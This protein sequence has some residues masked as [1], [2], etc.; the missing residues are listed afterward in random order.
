MDDLSLIHMLLTK[1][2]R[3][4]EPR[5]IGFV[6]SLDL[7]QFD[8]DH[9]GVAKSIRLQLIVLR[10]YIPSTT[11]PM[12]S[13]RALR[14][15]LGVCAACARQQH[16]VARRHFVTAPILRFDEVRESRL[17]RVATPSFWSSLIP[18][19]FRRSEQ[20]A[21][22]GEEGQEV[23]AVA[24]PKARRKW[25]PYTTFII[26]AV[27]IGSNAIQMISL[28]NEMT[29]FSRHTDVKLALLREVVQKVRRGEMDDVE[30]KRAL[31]TGDPAA[32]KE[33]E[34]VVKEIEDTDVLWE[35]HQRKEAKK[36]AKME[37]RRLKEEQ[38]RKSASPIAEVP[39]DGDAGSS[40]AAR[41]KFLM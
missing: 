23:P 27:L 40:R 38:E 30:V 6:R 14:P 4:D 24:P 1:A 5:S 12:A 41:P 33:W 22:Q 31:G 32:E 9:G 21:L 3:Y 17:P 7:V 8:A 2:T 36:A 39:E 18:K 28:R 37:E 10:S 29:A 11:I 26:L 35:A 15:V 34:D 13:S 25:N 16:L 20:S 19:A